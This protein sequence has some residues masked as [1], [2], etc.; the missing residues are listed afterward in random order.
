MTGSSAV[1]SPP[2]AP[3]AGAAAPP[4]PRRRRGTPAFVLGAIGLLGLI[5][6]LEILPRAGLVP[7]RY[8]PTASEIGAALAGEVGDEA[9]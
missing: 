5:A 6:V 8:F 2:G 1:V 3:A 4:R 7:R 9:C